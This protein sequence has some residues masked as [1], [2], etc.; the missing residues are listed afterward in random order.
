MSGFFRG[1]AL[2]VAIT[3]A[4]WVAVL[5]RWHATSRD[6]STGDIVVY[7][8]LLPLT[9]FTTAVLLRWAWRG[10]QER[11]AAAEAAAATAAAGGAGVAAAPTADAQWRHMTVQLLD[12]RLLLS[13]GDLNGQ[14]MLKNF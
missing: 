1:V 10:A 6:M 12:A 11:Q 9:V 13:E 5:W 3:C 4:V 7:L 2:L 14:S 8:G